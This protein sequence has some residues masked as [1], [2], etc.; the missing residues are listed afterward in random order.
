[1]FLRGVADD[2]SDQAARQHDVQRVAGIHQQDQI[3]EER[4]HDETEHG[5]ERER[6][7]L[8]REKADDHAGQQDP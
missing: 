2:Q 1:M 3:G 5:A 7:H 4:A 6:M 8:R